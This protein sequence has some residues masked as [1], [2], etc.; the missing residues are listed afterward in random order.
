MVLDYWLND[1]IE[2][3]LKN[4]KI[5]KG[6]SKRYV[7]GDYHRQ[8]FNV[9]AIEKKIADLRTQY[10]SKNSLTWDV[11]IHEGEQLK[12][13]QK[14]NEQVS[15]LQRSTFNDCIK[16]F[17]EANC[18]Q[19]HKPSE[20]LHRTTIVENLRYL[21]GYNER[22]KALKVITNERNQGEIEFK[23]GIT[24]WQQ[25]WNKYPPKDYAEIGPGK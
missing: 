11:D 22:T 19:I 23:E 25:F 8:D 24:T 21:I 13:R 5:V 15:E 9:K 12:K 6:C 7:L 2:R 18:P 20:T 3:K 4:G 1:N 16:S 10:G 17:F 14:Y